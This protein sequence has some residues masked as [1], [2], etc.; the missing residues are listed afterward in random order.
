MNEAAMKQASEQ[1]K[2]MTSQFEAA[3]ARAADLENQLKAAHPRGD[4]ENQIAPTGRP[5]R[6]AG[7]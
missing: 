1:L 5:R 4:L 7:G 2:D 6:R 3:S